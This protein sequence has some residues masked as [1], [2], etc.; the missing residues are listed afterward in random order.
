[1]KKL[2]LVLGMVL[3]CSGCKMPWVNDKYESYHPK[4]S[5]ITVYPGRR[6]RVEFYTDVEK[7]WADSKTKKPSVEDLLQTTY[8]LDTVLEARERQIEAYNKWA[9]EKNKKNG[10]EIKEF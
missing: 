3:V 4:I 10:Y 1:M 5:D 9:Q 6:T 7:M 8:E 2:I